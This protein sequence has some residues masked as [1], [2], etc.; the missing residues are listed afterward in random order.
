MKHSRHPETL[1][2][3][4]AEIKNIS[5]AN[6]S[7]TQALVAHDPVFERNYHTVI[8]QLKKKTTD[9]KLENEQFFADLDYAALLEE[10]ELN[11]LIDR[12]RQ[13]MEREFMLDKQ[14]MEA[15]RQEFKN[16][17]EIE[18]QMRVKLSPEFL[19]AQRLLAELIAARASLKSM[20]AECNRLQQRLDQ[21]HAQHWQPIVREAA[22]VAAREIAA[23]IIGQLGNDPEYQ[24]LLAG[25]NAHPENKEINIAVA[26]RYHEMHQDLQAALS[27]RA[28]PE[29]LLEHVAPLKEAFNAHVEHGNL[30]GVDR[31]KDAIK[32]VLEP[33]YKVNEDIAV[34]GNA[35]SLHKSFKDL[36]HKY[37]LD[38]T[39]HDVLARFNPVR[40]AVTYANN[41]ECKKAL[42]SYHGT[43]RNEYHAHAD[44][45]E[46]LDSLV[47]Q[48][49]KN[50][51]HVTD[52]ME[53]LKT[54]LP[55]F[56]HGDHEDLGQ[57]PRQVGPK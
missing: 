30:T 51:R 53:R 39:Y 56:L 21:W 31:Q 26:Q 42:D 37:G 49:N 8:A 24:Q 9:R 57:S 43:L 5:S 28:S 50:K 35:F 20:I 27:T 32:K 22:M 23:H 7:V 25:L 40:L 48:V 47:Y 18:Q 17:Q 55:G 38:K 6:Q 3:Y 16:Y 15:I 10:K 41:P 13:A 33:I 45:R 36:C 19:E 46:T 12:I 52:L 34:A 4:Y 44:N 14:K 54:F 29:D 2:A 11:L 1:I